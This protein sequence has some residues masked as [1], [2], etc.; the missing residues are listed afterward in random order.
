LPLAVGLVAVTVLIAIFA[1]WTGEDDT[2][3]GSDAFAV[4]LTNL[5]WVVAWLCCAFGLG[6]PIRFMLV[7]N[8]DE[9][10]AIQLAL[11]IA[12]LL[13]LVA[14]LGRIGMLQFGGNIGACALLL[15][16]I[17]LGIEQFRRANQRGPLSAASTSA[18]MPAVGFFYPLPLPSRCCCSPPRAHP[19]GSGGRSSAATTR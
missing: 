17:G 10:T 13:V 7:R 14:F 5:P 18:K 4:L 2:H 19:A 9:A 3:M 12:L 16:G 15:F 11:G 8:A 6:W 1:G